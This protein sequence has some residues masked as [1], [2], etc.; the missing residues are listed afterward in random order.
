MARVKRGFKRA[1][2]RKKILTQAKGYFL[3]KSKLHRQARLAVRRAM[4][5][6]FR[7]RRTRKLEFRSLWTVR[8]N[9]AAR[10]HE[11]NYSR[12]VG[13]LRKAGIELDRKVLADIAVRDPEG[14]AALV[15][16]AKQAFASA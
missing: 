13:G 14:F 4:E 9:A 8:L 1:R 3:T 12:L 7:H 11:L 6:A 10:A 16:T 5:F 15:Q 2:R